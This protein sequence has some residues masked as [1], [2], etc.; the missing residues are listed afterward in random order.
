MRDKL[1]KKNT[2]PHKAKKDT[3][4]VKEIIS[5]KSDKLTNKNTKQ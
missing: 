1:K 2:E 3:K 4:Y 5:I